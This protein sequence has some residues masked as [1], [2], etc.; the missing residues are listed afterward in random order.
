[1]FGKEKSRK[2]GEGERLI[3]MSGEK[4]LIMGVGIGACAGGRGGIGNCLLYIG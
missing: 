1:M 3:G 2:L 4:G